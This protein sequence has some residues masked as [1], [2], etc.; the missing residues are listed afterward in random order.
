MN[1]W[2]VEQTT[3]EEK[4]NPLDMWK[5]IK[6]HKAI[7]ASK[8]TAAKSSAYINIAQSQPLIEKKT[9]LYVIVYIDTHIHTLFCITHTFAEW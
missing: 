6:Q 5:S 8:M 2:G 3:G 7:M 1:E 4:W 9:L